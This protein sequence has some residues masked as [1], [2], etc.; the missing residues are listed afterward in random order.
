LRQNILLDVVWDRIQEQD[1]QVFIWSDETYP[2]R[3]REI[4]NAPP[5]LCV[6]G[7]LKIEVEWG[8]AIVGTRRIIPYGCQVAERIAAKMVSSGITIIRGLALGVETV[9]HQA[10]L[11]AGGRT[12]AV[13]GCGVD[14]IYPPRNRQLAERILTSGALISDYPPGTPPEAN[15]SRRVIG[16][17]LV[18]C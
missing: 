4:D 6:R 13:L 2:I 5:V 18:Y 17:F 7:T 10:A 12:L 15:T 9:A 11:D 1:I 16:L 8:V 3:L 14:R